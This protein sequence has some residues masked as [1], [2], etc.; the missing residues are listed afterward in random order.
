[1]NEP[2]G[3]HT[4]IAAGGNADFFVSVS[5]PKTLMRIVGESVTND[6][7]VG[8][9]GR[10]TKVVCSDFGY[11]GLVVHNAIDTFEIDDGTVT[12]GAGLALSDVVSRLAD[13]GL[14][15]L[16]AQASLD[17]SVGGALWAASAADPT[18]LL[19]AARTVEL[20]SGGSLIS[21][22]GR[23]LAGDRLRR[24]DEY[25][26]RVTFAVIAKDKTE[27]QRGILQTRQVKF[28]REPSVR[29]RVRVFDEPPGQSV[30]E[31]AAGLGLAG[32][33]IGGAVISEKNPN[34]VINAGSAK[35][36]EVKE[37]ADRLKYR[38]KLRRETTLQEAVAWMGEW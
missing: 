38:I 10:G 34:Y 27:I 15:G 30:G 25:V 36:G 8:L 12:V 29:Q 20:V 37:L 24:G 17:G 21:V 3:K 18:G 16:E 33:R 11:R 35:A 23:S 2:M 6:L 9:I 14:G 4:A 1:M 13:N 31:L 7:K 26:T 5:E 28:R 22:A 19:E 32:E